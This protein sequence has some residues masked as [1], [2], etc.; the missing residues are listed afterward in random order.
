VSE[1][2]VRRLLKA[3]AVNDRQH[4]AAEAGVAHPDVAARGRSVSNCAI[5]PPQKGCYRRDMSL[6]DLTCSDFSISERSVL[7][8]SGRVGDGERNRDAGMGDIHQ[9]AGGRFVRRRDA[10][11]RQRVLAD[12]R[13]GEGREGRFGECDAL[14]TLARGHCVSLATKASSS[15]K[16]VAPILVCSW[17]FRENGSAYSASC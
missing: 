9:V 7:G 1:G 17:R 16:Y 2:R 15:Y 13:V 12:K 6:H 14:V 10:G 4:A 5:A 11:S 3:R 8:A